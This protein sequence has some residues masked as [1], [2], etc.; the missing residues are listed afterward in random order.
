MTFRDMKLTNKFML[1]T[2]SI[3]ILSI[4]AT[5]ALTLWEVRND[6][7]RQANAAQES[8]LKTFWELLKTKGSDFRIVN[9]QLLVGNYSVN[10]NFELPDKVKEL[11]G[12][13]ATIF[14]RDTRVTTNVLKPDGNRAVGTKLQGLAYDAI[15]KAGKKYRGET[16][17]LGIPYLTAYDPIRNAQ[18]ETIGVLYVGIKKSEYFASFNSVMVIVCILAAVL[19]VTLNMVVY[20]FVR[21][22][23]KPLHEAVNAVNKVADGNLSA[24]IE[25][26]SRDET[27]LLL[28]AVG[29][30]VRRLRQIV[31]EVKT[32]AD[33][34]AAG[35]Q[36]LSSSAQQ[37]S[38]G[39]S[40]QAA[41]AEEAS[42]S[43]EQMAASI[44][45]NADNARQTDSITL[46]AST[47][48]GEAGKTVVDTVLAMREISKKIF[49]IEEIARQ[50]NLLALNA[51][52]E[53][54]RAGEHGRGFAV[55]ASEVRKLA[56]RS[57]AA[58][59]DISQ[60]SSSSVAVAETAGKMLAKLVPD[61]Q[62]AAELVQDMSAASN[63]QHTG[64][65]QINQAI[66]QLDSVIQQNASAAEEMAATAEELSSQA[67]QLQA[68]VAFFRISDTAV[69]PLTH[70]QTATAPLLQQ[71]AAV[72][73]PSI[74]DTICGFPELS[75]N[76]AQTELSVIS[77]CSAGRS[78]GDARDADFE[79]I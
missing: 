47:D 6:L 25:V 69:S 13:T 56:E 29:N 38:R 61:I 70:P 24:Q 9:D 68:N 52:I 53:A 50:T 5:T 55:V 30:M 65:E 64:A 4:V 22:V 78:R 57:Q 16:D 19:T 60:L 35:S 63:E 2:S 21:R 67:E 36:Q 33:N 20:F 37:I 75:R 49:I 8:R 14:M 12:G 44:R 1:I 18:G 46:Q 7:L 74:H 17:I 34:V 54:A 28:L 23:L 41:S 71:A 32:A 76:P 79:R 51:A 10:G 43:I 45:Q 73:P 59:G 42:V 31:A 26:N 58:A 62:K 66:Q 15:F 11:F 77:L 39:A 72:R 27:G 3:I 40:E 48:A